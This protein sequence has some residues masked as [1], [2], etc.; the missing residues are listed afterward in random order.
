[1]G[2]ELHTEEVNMVTSTRDVASNET[3]SLISAG[4]VQGTPVYNMKKEKLGTVEDLM[5]DKLSGVVAYAVLSFGGFLGIGDRH[6]P[7]PWQV[8]DYDTNQGGYVI[9]L[10]K[11][12]LKGAPSYGVDENVDW[13]DRKWGQKVHDYYEVPPYWI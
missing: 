4:K 6:H 10:D 12:T 3:S 13:A 1:L 11:E 7:L 5:I 9:D 2:Y 8:L